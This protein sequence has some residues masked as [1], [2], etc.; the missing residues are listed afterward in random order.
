MLITEL[1]NENFN[2]LVSLNK[3]NIKFH[4][5]FNKLKYCLTKVEKKQLE[6]ELKQLIIC[7]TSKCFLL[8]NKKKSIGFIL[9]SFK[10]ERARICELFIL[11]EF[12]KLGLGK[13]LIY[14]IIDWLKKNTKTKEIILDVDHSNTTAINFYEKMNLKK[15]FIRMKTSF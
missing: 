8:K 5:Q 2:E 10:S 6:V 9:I 15:D 14:F 11:K 12:R 7:K 3:K 13:S 4:Q 1:K